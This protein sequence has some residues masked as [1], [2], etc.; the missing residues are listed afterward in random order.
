MIFAGQLDGMIDAGMLFLDKG[1]W[2]L[3]MKM[4]VHICSFDAF[5]HKMYSRKFSIFLHI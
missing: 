2:T 3:H 4:Q 5:T 1:L